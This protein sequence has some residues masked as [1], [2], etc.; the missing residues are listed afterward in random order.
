ML[1]QV[2][3]LAGVIAFAAL[4]RFFA[5]RTR[6][7]ETDSQGNPILR[8]N[9]FLLIQTLL[10]GSFFLAVGVYQWFVPLNH[11]YSGNLLLLCYLPIS[12]FVL[13]IAGA[14]IAA[15]YRATLRADTI[16]VLRWPLGS[17]EYKVAELLSVDAV[18]LNTVLRFSGD[19]EYTIR[20]D[21]WGREYFIGRLPADPRSR[22]P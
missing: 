5:T 16:Q 11:R 21:M 6:P 12:I 2:V 9:P 22:G 4:S 13:T 10:C 19:L 14:A 20:P 18:G 17:R 15:R 1:R 7:R 8:V 3:V